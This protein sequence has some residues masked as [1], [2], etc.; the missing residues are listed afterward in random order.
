MPRLVMRKLLFKQLF[1]YVLAILPKL[2]YL[3]ISRILLILSSSRVDDND[4]LWGEV[5]F[6]RLLIEALRLAILSTLTY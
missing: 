5:Y 4:F 2:K 6:C 1:R 3:F